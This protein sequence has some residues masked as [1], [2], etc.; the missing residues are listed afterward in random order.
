MAAAQVSRCGSAL[1]A[2]LRECLFVCQ[3][4]SLLQ[5]LC[6]QRWHLLVFPHRVLLLVGAAAG[7]AAETV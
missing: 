2:G 6:E 3:R 5:G 4:S 1:G 7:R